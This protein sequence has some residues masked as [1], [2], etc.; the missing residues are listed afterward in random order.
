[1]GK[2][3]NTRLTGKERFELCT[4]YKENTERLHKLLDVDIATEATSKLVMHRPL[5][6]TDI[7]ATRA[8]LGIEKRQLKARTPD[9]VIQDLEKRVSVHDKEIAEL[10]QEIAKLRQPEFTLPSG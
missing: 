6:V 2:A 3:K 1:M 10:K 9:S 5:T 8:I 7:E 4:W